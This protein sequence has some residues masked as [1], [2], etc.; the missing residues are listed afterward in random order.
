MLTNQKGTSFQSHETASFAFKHTFPPSARS[1][2][3]ASLDLGSVL[4]KKKEYR[5]ISAP[6]EWKNMTHRPLG[7]EEATEKLKQEETSTA[8]KSVDETDSIRTDTVRV[9]SVTQVEDDSS[10]G[11]MTVGGVDNWRYWG[12]YDGH[13]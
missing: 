7:M 2:F 12:V 3:R 9:G 13:S 10:W 8:S 11:R 4:Q 6:I 5:N 1:Q